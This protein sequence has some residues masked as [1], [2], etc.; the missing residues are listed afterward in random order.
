MDGNR[1]SS[2]TGEVRS[3]LR[4]GTRPSRTGP[5]RAGRPR[6]PRRVGAPLLLL[7]VVGASAANAER[8]AANDPK[9]RSAFAAPALPRLDD[10]WRA[11]GVAFLDLPLGLRARYEARA[12]HR[13][14]APRDGSSLFAELMD[15]ANRRATRLLESRFALSR[16]L[17]PHLEIELA[18]A[19]R[20]PLTMF[21]LTRIEDQRVAAMIRFVP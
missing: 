18:W 5:G 15:D 8:P 7:L 6:R 13:F 20:S 9:E 2:A 11:R 19:A 12:L 4:S 16:A 17:A 10:H 3:G 21:D 1:S 14:G